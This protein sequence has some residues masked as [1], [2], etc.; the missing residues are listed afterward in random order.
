M[1]NIPQRTAGC[2][3]ENNFRWSR[4]KIKQM[5]VC[6]FFYCCHRVI[7]QLTAES[8]SGTLSADDSNG[9]DSHSQFCTAHHLPAC[10]EYAVCL[11]ARGALQKGWLLNTET[12]KTIGG[13][14]I[15]I[16]ICS[17][18]KEIFLSISGFNLPSCAGSCLYW[19]HFRCDTKW[20]FQWNLCLCSF[21][22]SNTACCS[23]MLSFGVTAKGEA[24]FK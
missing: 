8:L 13:C 22:L 18:Q 15:K 3:G 24:S 17:S 16:N 4:I 12:S 9:P 1:E 11:L 7:C 5:V 14:I 19:R 10:N 2:C 20:G 6:F 23:V 21:F